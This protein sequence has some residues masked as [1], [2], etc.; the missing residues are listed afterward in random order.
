MLDQVGI[1]SNVNRHVMKAI[2]GYE[3]VRNQVMETHEKKH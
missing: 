3:N 2:G 1:T